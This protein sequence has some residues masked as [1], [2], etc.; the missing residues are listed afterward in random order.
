MQNSLELSAAQQFEI[1]K[2]NRIIESTTD[3]IALRKLTKQ[4]LTA[5]MVQ[6]AATDWAIRQTAPRVGKFNG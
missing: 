2:M 4:L 5:L 3:V 6:K 1:E